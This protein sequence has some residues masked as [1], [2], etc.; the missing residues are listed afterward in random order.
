[1]RVDEGSEEIA[2]ASVEE[3]KAAG[4]HGMDQMVV[5]IAFVFKAHIG[6]CFCVCACMSVGG[7]NCMQTWRPQK[8]LI[9]VCQGRQQC[10]ST[11]ILDPAIIQGLWVRAAVPERETGEITAEHLLDLFDLQFLIL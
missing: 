3:S 1:M 9:L 10:L 11:R 2:I 8:P 5:P 4:E 7:G 6:T